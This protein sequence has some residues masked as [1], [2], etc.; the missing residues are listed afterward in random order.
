M[1]VCCQLLVLVLVSIV[2]MIISFII[3]INK[4]GCKTVKLLISVLI[5]T[6]IKICLMLGKMIASDVQYMQKRF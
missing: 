4:C 3:F 2:L 1:L 6:T 5:V